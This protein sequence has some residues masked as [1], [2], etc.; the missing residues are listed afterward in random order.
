MTKLTKCPLPWTQAFVDVNKSISPCCAPM[1]LGNLSDNS[2][3]EIYNGK[4]FSLL[5]EGLSADKP[6][7]LSS[8]CDNCYSW[9]KVKQSAQSFDELYP[10]G[11]HTETALDELKSSHSVFVK[12]YTAVK[13]SYLTGCQPSTELKPLRVEVQIGEHCD[14]ECIMCWQDHSKPRALRKKN[15]EEIH[16]LVPYLLEITITGGEPTIFPGFWE[17]V[18]HFKQQSMPFARLQLL[19]HGQHL[20]DNLDKF[21]G[22]PYLGFCVNV[23]GPTKALYEKIRKGAD[24][25]RLNNS[26]A[27]VSKACEKELGWSLNTT[28]LLMKSNIEHI[29]KSIE[30][31]NQYNASW[32]CGLVAGDYTP[33]ERSP[34]FFAENIFRFGHLGYG[35]ERIK[36]L[37]QKSLATAEQNDMLSGANTAAASLR[38]SI[39][40]VSIIHQIKIS[41][42]KAEQ[43]SCLIDANALSREIQELIA[44]EDTNLIFGADSKQR[45]LAAGFIKEGE[46]KENAGDYACAVKCY[47]KANTVYQELNL[48]IESIDTDICIGRCMSHTM[49]KQALELLHKCQ[50]QLT[51]SFGE[52]HSRVAIAN[53][54]LGKA[55]A[56]TGNPDDAETHLRNA[57]KIFSALYGKQ[58]FSSYVALSAYELGKLYHNTHDPKATP[59]FR[60]SVRMFELHLGADSSLTRE[61]AQ[62][63]YNQLVSEKRLTTAQ[64]VFEQFKLKPK[65]EPRARR[66]ILLRIVKGLSSRMARTL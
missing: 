49:P 17:L 50:R 29:D 7:L 28:F 4:Q 21:E 62:F 12:N 6:S 64:H 18:E 22:I 44:N 31:A 52:T 39:A 3:L 10:V 26:L 33:I 13:H 36:N 57:Y 54:E 41:K 56:I 65:R 51:Q 8:H 60:K 11:S 40:E 38:A 2:I 53:L 25:T 9:N 37:L 46:R 59:L 55:H 63:Y 30:F 23:D 16:D 42:T 35:K 14:I 61:A 48:S 66:N 15:L 45:Q 32:S 43:L 5:R 1:E 19:T 20:G 27:V 47:E 34:T 24:W 58:E